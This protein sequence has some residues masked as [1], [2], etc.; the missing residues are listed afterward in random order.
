MD[1]ARGAYCGWI[2]SCGALAETMGDRHRHKMPHG[3]GWNKVNVIGQV[4]LAA[5]FALLAIRVVGWVLPGSWFDQS[6]N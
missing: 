4:F 6:F 2:C 3:P 1:G 5:A